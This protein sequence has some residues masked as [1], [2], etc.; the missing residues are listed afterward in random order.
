MRHAPPKL[1]HDIADGYASSVSQTRVG[2]VFMA[3]SQESVRPSFRWR[4]MVSELD[5]VG[6]RRFS[7]ALMRQ[8]LGTDL[9]GSSRSLDPDG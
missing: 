1:G 2:A 7:G 4:T 6:Y 3:A 8:G 9:R 5:T